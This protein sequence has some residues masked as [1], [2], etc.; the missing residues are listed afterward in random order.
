MNPL[1][2]LRGVLFDSAY[3]RESSRQ[4]RPR[5]NPRSRNSCGLHSR[6]LRL[7]AQELYKYPRTT[8][9]PNP[10]SG[11]DRARPCGAYSNET[12]QPLRLVSIFDERRVLC[13]PKSPEASV[14]PLPG[15]RYCRCAR[16]AGLPY[17][18]CAK[19]E[20]KQ[21]CLQPR[22]V[23]ISGR[24]AS[25]AAWRANSSAPRRCGRRADFSSEAQSIRFATTGGAIESGE[26]RTLWVRLGSGRTRHKGI[27]NRSR[28]NTLCCRSQSGI[29]NAI[30]NPAAAGKQS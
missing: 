19:A 7:T 24:S 29:H 1:N 26:W 25:R 11:G 2:S 8:S 6:F 12:R 30:L 20:R 21:L 14:T 16:T 23:V 17:D 10:P 28:P 4:K 22:Y 15:H 18:A 27:Y 9:L 13:H 3:Y 5:A